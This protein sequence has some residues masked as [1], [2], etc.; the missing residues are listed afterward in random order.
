MYL[1]WILVAM[2]RNT[3]IAEPVAIRKPGA[4]VGTSF[5]EG[6]SEARSGLQHS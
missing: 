1:E 5:F 3:G 6:E 2:I 4:V